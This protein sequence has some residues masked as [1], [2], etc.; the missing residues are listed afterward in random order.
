MKIMSRILPLGLGLAASLLATGCQ[1]VSTTITP[2]ADEPKA[3]PTQPDA[4]YVLRT[5]PTKAHVRL[6]E[7][8]AVPTDTG[9]DSGTVEAAL[10]ESAATLGADAI[11]V[12]LDPTQV[13]GA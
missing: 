12:V 2:A 1:T 9:V 13:V 3:A 4:I 7:V 11:V 8:R 10:R 6:G 5:A